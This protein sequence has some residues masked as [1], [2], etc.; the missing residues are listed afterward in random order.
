VTPFVL[1]VK[2]WAKTRNIS[3]ASSATLSSYGHTLMAI[4]FLQ[5]KSVVPNLQAM[6]ENKP[7]V[8]TSATRNFFFSLK[9]QNKT[10]QKGNG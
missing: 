3:D 5:L 2:K 7:R 4:Q 10:K 8:G 6:A 9:K 1:A